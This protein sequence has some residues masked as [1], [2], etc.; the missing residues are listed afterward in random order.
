[1]FNCFCSQAK[2]VL[3]LQILE[4]TLT[5]FLLAGCAH[6]PTNTFYPIGIYGVANT[7]DFQKISQA[8]FNLVCGRA[9]RG[10][11][12][13]ASQHGLKVLASPGTS[14]GPRFDE[15]SARRTISAFDA[16]PSLWAWYLAD[17]PDLNGIAPEQINQAHRFLK[18]LPAHKPT[19]LVLSS[20]LLAPPYASIPDIV[21][22]DRYPIP[23][24]PLA[25][26]GQHVRLARFA[27]GKEK[28]LLAVVQAFDWSH[29]PELLPGEKNLRPPTYPELRC[30]TYLA[31]AL[32]A[33]GLFYYAYDDGRWKMTQQPRTWESLKK[34]AAEVNQNQP[35]FQAAHVWR[36]YRHQFSDWPHRFN[37]ALESSITPAFLRVSN[38]NHHIP[39]GD[40][41]LAVNNTDLPQGYQIFVPGLIDGPAPVLGE[42]RK[43]EITQQCLADHFNPFEVHIYGPLRFTR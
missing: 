34:V 24:L 21:M 17:E 25:N 13:A 6:P 36:A 32:R 33:N 19:A 5:V 2:A 30:M 39:A 41:L 26:F 22:I 29:Y 7:N 31:L 28:P 16:H 15:M 4:V 10:Y 14:A 38:T 12:E 37:A 1:M 11:L 9:D 20:A 18:S 3:N 43:L 27:T 35:L 42:N 40:Y 8:G 23:W